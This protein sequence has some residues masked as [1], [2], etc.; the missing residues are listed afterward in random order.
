MRRRP[1]HERKRPDYRCSA[2]DRW[3]ERLSYST[4]RRMRNQAAPMRDLC[5]FTSRPSAFLARYI[6][7]RAGAP[8]VI[9][10]AVLGAVASSIGAQY[11]VKMLVDTLAATSVAVASVWVAFAILTSLIAADNLLWR[12]A[13]YIA[14]FTF[15]AVTGDIRR[16]LFRHLTG[17]APSY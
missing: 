4:I 8:G 13:M 11:G 6:K 14:S 2:T 17:H 5:T 3:A 10:A 9:L 16:D 7:L 15:T 12:L 1:S